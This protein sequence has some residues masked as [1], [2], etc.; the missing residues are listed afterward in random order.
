MWRIWGVQEVMRPRL[1]GVALVMGGLTAN[2][3]QRLVIG[4][5]C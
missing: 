4:V 3:V 5:A 2:T 1:S